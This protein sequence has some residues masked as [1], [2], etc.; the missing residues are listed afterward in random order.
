MQFTILSSY[1]CEILN[2]MTLE[3][4]VLVF[5]F[6]KYMWAYD[7]G[8]EDGGYMVD[9]PAEVFSML[10]Y[11]MAI[12]TE[13]SDNIIYFPCKQSGIGRFYR[14]NY[15]LVLCTPKIQLRRSS[16]INISRKLN[17]TTKIG[18]YVLQYNRKNWMI[19]V[20]KNF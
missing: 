18:K 1:F 9:E 12:L 20:I 15:H 19:S 16:W 13:A 5:P 17:N 6:I 10:K 3:Y 14:E 11:A 2:L 7:N 4:A 8:P